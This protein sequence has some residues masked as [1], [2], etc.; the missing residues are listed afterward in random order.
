LAESAFLFAEAAKPY[1][2]PAPAALTATLYS[3]V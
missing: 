1:R 2:R 3:C